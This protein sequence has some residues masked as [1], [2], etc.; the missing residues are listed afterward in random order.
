MNVGIRSWPS[1]GLVLVLG[2][3]SVES[4]ATT[5]E[6]TSESPQGGVI[7]GI[8]R[9]S[10]TQTGIADALVVLECECLTTYQERQTSARGAYSFG[11]LPPGDY[12]IQVLAGRSGASQTTKLAEGGEYRVDF[13]VVLEEG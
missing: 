13:L 1:L 5:P 6:P 10:T 4:T 2:C 9:D 12:T 3:A 11:D 8:V 7:N